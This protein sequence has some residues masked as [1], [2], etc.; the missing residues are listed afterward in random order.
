LVG[1][2]SG[3]R[4]RNHKLG[5]DGRVDEI[6]GIWLQIALIVVVEKLPENMK[7]DVTLLNLRRPNTSIVKGKWSNSSLTEEWAWK[8]KL[9]S[10]MVHHLVEDWSK[11]V[12]EHELPDEL[13]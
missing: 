1:D 5:E 12:S 11:H 6:H 10:V 7:I 4:L 13:S 8:V 9:D 3:C 2:A